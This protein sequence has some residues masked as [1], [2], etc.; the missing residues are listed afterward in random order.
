MVPNRPEREVVVQTVTDHR[1]T[2]EQDCREQ[3]SGIFRT[4]QQGIDKVS[5]KALDFAPKGLGK[6]PRPALEQAKSERTFPGSEED[7]EE[8]TKQASIGEHQHRPELDI[9]VRPHE[10]DNCNHEEGG[11]QIKR[12]VHSDRGQRLT[13]GNTCLAFEYQTLC[14]FASTDGQQEIEEDADEE[15]LQHGKG[16]HLPNG[17]QEDFPAHGADGKGQHEGQTGE[18]REQDSLGRRQALLHEMKGCGEVNK[19]RGSHQ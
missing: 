1:N 3:H 10:R 8:Q 13:E 5:E 18:E 2:G 16:T 15:E 11:Q 14:Q 6:H 17:I 7:K 19:T 4:Q 12:L 9:Q